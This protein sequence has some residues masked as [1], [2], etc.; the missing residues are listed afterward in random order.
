ML[1]IILMASRVKLWG[2]VIIRMGISVK[3]LH[4][5]FRKCRINQEAAISEEIV[6]TN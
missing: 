3:L 4:R 1:V 2:N 5:L 6:L